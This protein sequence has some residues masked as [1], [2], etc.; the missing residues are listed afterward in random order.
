[1]KSKQKGITL[2]AL[3]ITIIILL[4]LAG[5]TINLLTEGGLFEKTK[6]AKENS[7]NAQ[8]KEN[9]TLSEYENE[10]NKYINGSRLESTGGKRAVL[11]D[12]DTDPKGIIV[13]EGIDNEDAKRE[14]YDDVNKYDAVIV[15]A[16]E[17]NSELDIIATTSFIIDKG[18]YNTSYIYNLVLTGSYNA[19]RGYVKIDTTN[20]TIVLVWKGHSAHS[21]YQV[22]GINY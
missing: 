11:F 6:L 10:M 8:L 16:G 18:V 20:N 5:I 3:V 21:I 22:I 7:K 14:L 17:L 12:G 13:S 1:M 19:C 15:N 9:E 2:V 4:I